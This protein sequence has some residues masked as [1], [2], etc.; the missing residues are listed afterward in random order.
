ML[1]GGVASEPAGNATAIVK[2]YE[3]TSS[4]KFPPGWFQVASRVNQP[5]VRQAQQKEA[6][7][8]AASAAVEKMAKEAVRQAA[9]AADEKMAKEA[10][11]QAASAADEKMA[12]YDPT[13]G[14]P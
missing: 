2:E 6:V 8:Q 1:S 3:I 12:T 14:N 4:D 10:V 11:R 5:E 13:V 7:R 9:S